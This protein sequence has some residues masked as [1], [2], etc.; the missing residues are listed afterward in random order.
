MVHA[1]YVLASS[2]AEVGIWLS[3]GR[4]QASPHKAY[5]GH[6]G[7]FPLGIDDVE[8]TFGIMS[9]LEAEAEARADAGLVNRL[10]GRQPEMRIINQKTHDGLSHVEPSFV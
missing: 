3:S 2:V 7:V 1:K 4:L 9:A 5:R 10:Q 6:P 8:E